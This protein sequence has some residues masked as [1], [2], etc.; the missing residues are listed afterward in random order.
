V[1]VTEIIAPYRVPV[2]N[3]L[4]ARPEVSL[5]VIFL[6]ENDPT[7]R[8][9][10]IYKEEIKFSYQ[11]LPSWRNR[12]GDRGILLN[13]GMHAALDRAKP[14][15]VLCGGYNHLAYWQASRWAQANGVPFI[16]WSESTA[17]DQRP[18][19]KTVELIK[20]RFLKSC[21][22]F[23]V[24]GKSSSD[25]LKQLGIKASLIFSAPNAVDTCLFSK[26]AAAARQDETSIRRARNLPE[27]YF[28]YVGR[29]VTEKGIFDLLEAYAQLNSEIRSAVG[30]VFVG[31]GSQQ[32]ELAKRA[33][34]VTSGCIQFLNFVHREDLPAIYALADAF[35][36]PTHSD[37][38][39]LVVNEAMACSLP[40]IATNIAGCTVDL[41][42]HGSNGFVVTARDKISLSCSMAALAEDS[43]LRTMMG[44]RSRARIDQYSPAA[45]AHGVVQAAMSAYTNNLRPAY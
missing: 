40:V 1:I 2:F 27:R 17:L 9:W 29:L 39:G 35:I 15:V 31:T 21:A 23:L 24:P 14:D 45:W 18:Q 26:L 3:A 6:S 33:S 8:Q 30:L 38:W 22:A 16:L 43:A 42:E 4:A 44:Q 20:S 36:L 37:P 7:L 11:V 34:K 12:F 13:R 41:V 19:R 5:H 32:A 10:R 28:L 25:Y